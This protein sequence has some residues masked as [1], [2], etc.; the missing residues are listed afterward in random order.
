MVSSND[1]AFMWALVKILQLLR[2]LK[3]LLDTH[4]L[5]RY[6]LSLSEESSLKI[7]NV[8]K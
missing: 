3:A 4:S 8:L 7:E 6:V 1:V 5:L 2:N